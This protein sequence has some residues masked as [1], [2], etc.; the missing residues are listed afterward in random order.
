MEIK[1]QI[2]ELAQAFA[3]RV[4]E[5]VGQVQHQL[6]NETTSNITSTVTPKMETLK[7]IEE[8]VSDYSNWLPYY[9]FGV[10]AMFFFMFVVKMGVRKWKNSRKPTAIEEKKHPAP[11]RA[12]EPTDKK[13]D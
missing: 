11:E 13:N 6:S 4:Y 2:S 7:A 9:A 3:Q 12:K 8:G 10:L 1:Q 5:V